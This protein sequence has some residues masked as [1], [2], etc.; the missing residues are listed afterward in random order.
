MVSSGSSGT[1]DCTTNLAFSGIEA[2][3]EVVERDLEDVG[4]ELFRMLEVVGQRLHV[5]DEHV[6]VVFVLQPH[7]IGERADIVSEMQRAGRAVAGENSFLHRQS[8]M[9]ACSVSL[10]IPAASQSDEVGGDVFHLGARLGLEAHR[11]AEE[12]RIMEQALERLGAEVALADML[13][14]DRRAS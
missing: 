12:A 5:G 1:I 7:A 14:G 2:D 11:D 4:L 3:R 13:D 8:L 10:A 9:S 6:G